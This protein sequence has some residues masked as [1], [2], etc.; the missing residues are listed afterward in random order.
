MAGL[1]KRF[2]YLQ[3]IYKVYYWQGI[4]RTQIRI[5]KHAALRLIERY[6][7]SIDDLRHILKTGKQVKK[8]RKDGDIGIIERKIGKRKIRIVF[9]VRNNIVWIITVE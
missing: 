7:L 8:P 3:S 6:D 5:K 4:H 9:K 2:L 1:I